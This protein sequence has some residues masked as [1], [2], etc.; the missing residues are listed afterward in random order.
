MLFRSINDK[1]KP[2]SSN[3]W[4]AGVTYDRWKGIE[5]QLE[6]YWKEMNN[7]IEYRDGA[8]YY[9][10]SIGWSDK[11]SAGSGRSYGIEFMARKNIGRVT[12]SFSYTLSNTLGGAAEIEDG[13][14]RVDFQKLGENASF[15]VLATDSYGLSVA[16]PIDF[17]VELPGAK[18]AEVSSVSDAGAVTDNV[19]E[20][21]LA[22]LFRSEERRV[23]KECVSTCRS[24][25][26]PY[27]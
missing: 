18:L 17:V 23:G 16:L 24:R 5:L 6:A 13:I 7:L 25:W 26:S 3:L 9:G 2:I 20:V 12:G 8:G 1:I 10:S 4:A 11:V 14:L 21:P 27:H 19:W 15:S 22:D